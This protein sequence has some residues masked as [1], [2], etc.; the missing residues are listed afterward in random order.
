M[1][2][3]AARPFTRPVSRALASTGARQ[4]GPTSSLFARDA[5]DA[6]SAEQLGNEGPQDGPRWAG[7]FRR[8]RDSRE[9]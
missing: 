2:M 8:T 6:R 4:V 7:Q 5:D 1:E 3:P 9:E